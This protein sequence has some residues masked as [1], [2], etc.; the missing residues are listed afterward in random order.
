MGVRLLGVSA[1]ALVPVS[2][3]Q[4]WEGHGWAWLCRAVGRASAPRQAWEGTGSR[5]VWRWHGAEGCA[6]RGAGCRS[7]GPGGRSLS[8]GTN[9]RLFTACLVPHCC[10]QHS[11]RKFTPCRPWLSLLLFSSPSCILFFPSLSFISVFFNPFL[12]FSQHF[13]PC[14]KLP[15]VPSRLPPATRPSPATTVPGDGSARLGARLPPLISGVQ[16]PLGQD[17]RLSAHSGITPH[18]S[19]LPFM[20]GRFTRS[21]Q[22]LGDRRVLQDPLD[23]EGIA[24]L[25]A[26]CWSDLDVAW[27]LDCHHQPLLSHQGPLCPSAQAETNPIFATIRAFWVLLGVFPRSVIQEQLLGLRA[28]HGLIAPSNVLLVDSQPAASCHSFLVDICVVLVAGTAEWILSIPSLDYIS[29]SR[30]GS[31]ALPA[32]P[33]FALCQDPWT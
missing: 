3:P 13:L 22:E 23:L 17:F 20:A 19:P 15:V 16:V 31:L 1:K 25:L 29:V 27:R 32:A 7:P 30:L 24:W 4:S 10:L 8:V 12:C 9:V 5:C 2:P 6:E 21:L 33:N 28:V 11:V 18:P 26:A 14:S